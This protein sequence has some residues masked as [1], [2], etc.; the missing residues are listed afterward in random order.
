MF[1]HDHLTGQVTRNLDGVVVQ[2][3]TNQAAFDE[4]AAFLQGGGIPI[5]INVRVPRSVSP[6]QIRLA[7]NQLNLRD[8][9]ETAIAAGSR[10]LRDEWQYTAEFLRDNPEI[11]ALGE[12]LGADL[13]ALF[14]L[15]A[16]L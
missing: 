6:R 12:A 10:D 11:V 3:V 15:A 7:L 2:P 13:D 16:T 1:T 9:V 14:I 5:Q 8:Q 4:Y